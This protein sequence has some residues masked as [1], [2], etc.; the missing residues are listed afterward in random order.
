[1]LHKDLKNALT[2]SS[3]PP[4]MFEVNFE[5]QSHAVHTARVSPVP[6]S[7]AI[8]QNALRF[9][10]KKSRADF[11][12]HQARLTAKGLKFHPKIKNAEGSW[13]SPSP[14]FLFST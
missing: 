2:K 10:T 9:T 3:L 11:Y 5:F 14:S 1:M 13:E 12:F 6:V 4:F 8:T 7:Y